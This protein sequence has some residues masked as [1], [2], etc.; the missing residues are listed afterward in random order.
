MALVRPQVRGK[1]SLAA[2]SHENCRILPPLCRK[3]NR[4]ELTNKSACCF[5]D[6]IPGEGFVGSFQRFNGFENAHAGS[7]QERERSG[8][9][10]VDSNRFQSLSSFNGIARSSLSSRMFAKS[11]HER[12]EALDYQMNSLINLEE[13]ISTINLNMSSGRVK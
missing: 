13:E 10:V 2:Q 7:R 5:Q 6:Q 4:S 8:D 1:L 3:K 11:R 9:L 12:Q